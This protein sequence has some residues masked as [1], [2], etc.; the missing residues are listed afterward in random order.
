MNE[1]ARAVHQMLTTQT[2]D[3]S[4]GLSRTEAM[5]MVELHPLFAQRLEVSPDQVNGPDSGWVLVVPQAQ[6]SPA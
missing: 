3:F 4:K 6:P 1:L 5:A 2:E